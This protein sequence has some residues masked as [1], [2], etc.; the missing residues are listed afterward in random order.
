MNE[1][2]GILAGVRKMVSNDSSYLA[3]IVNVFWTILQFL[4]NVKY[5]FAEIQILGVAPISF[6][7]APNRIA[8]K[9]QAEEKTPSC[10]DV[11]I[12]YKFFA[13][14]GWTTVV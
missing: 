4:E 12:I 2:L 14:H 9:T 3:V 1:A 7:F 6:Q 13:P 10:D 11:L 8:H 5:F